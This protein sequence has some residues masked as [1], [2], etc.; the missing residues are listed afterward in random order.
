MSVLGNGDGDAATKWEGYSNYEYVSRQITRKVSRAIEAYSLLQSAGAERSNLDDFEYTEARSM[1]LDAAMSLKVEIER[2][3][4]A[5]GNGSVFADIEERWTEG[6][7]TIDQGYIHAFHQLSVQDDGVPGWV[8]TFVSDIRLAAWELGY[9]Q[10]GRK[11]ENND[12][13]PVEEDVNEMFKG[14]QL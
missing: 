10:A 1:I 9:L 2:E 3:A 4:A 6:D 8:F 11:V 5:Q 12:L 13:G 7:E 14:I